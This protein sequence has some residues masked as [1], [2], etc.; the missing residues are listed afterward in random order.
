EDLRDLARLVDD[1]GR[2]KNTPVLPA[3]HRLL[4]PHTVP[5][6]DRVVLIDE[7]RIRQL[8]FLL[9]LLVRFRRVGAYAEDYRVEAVESRQ[10]IAERAGLDGTA[11]RVVLRVEEQHYVLTFEIG[12]LDLLASVVECGEVGGFFALGSDGFGFGHC[13]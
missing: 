6:S 11:R 10:R 1:E 7:Q 3:I 5:L 8:K 13:H 4:A 9:E 2:S 12:E